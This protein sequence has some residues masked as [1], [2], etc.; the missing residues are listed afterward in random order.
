MRSLRVVLCTL[1]CAAAVVAAIPAQ[2]ALAE[3]PA[4]KIARLRAEAT[5]VQRTIDSMNG[6]IERL[7]EDY[8][9]NQ[10]ALAHTIVAERETV[11]RL[12]D[13]ERRLVAAQLLLDQRMRAI[14]VLGPTTGLDQLLGATDMHDALTRVKYQASVVTADRNAIHR[15]DD[16]RA[17]LRSIAGE[18]AQQRRAQER[19]RERLARQ[20]AGIQARLGAQR[21]YLAR[22]TQA[23]KRAVEAERRRQEA[24]RRQA[25]LRRLAAERAARA[26]AR[27]GHWVPRFRGGGGSRAA[28]AAVVFAMAQL[29][30]PYLWGAVG[31]GSY[32]CSGL[33]MAAYAHAGVS[34]PRTSRSQWY[35]G[36]HVE[37]ADL[38]PGDLL[39]FADNL[40]VPSTIHH[41]GIYAGRGL[42]VEAPYSGA[43]VRMSS[44][45]RGDFI[46][47]VRPTG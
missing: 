25:L 44:I 3:T 11:Q 36:P 14:Y 10:E 27:A 43:S 42:M 45:G 23:V 31:P 18:L 22:V 33:T 21:R 7:V 6:Q 40:S 47:A 39:F 29:G 28:R 4:Q 9:A 20:R 30:K 2:P 38:A 24:L 46:G 17:L 12:R 13:A 16:A 35:A 5:R 41:V 32:D 26:R 15:V 34:L 19:L 1:L 37:L 8:N